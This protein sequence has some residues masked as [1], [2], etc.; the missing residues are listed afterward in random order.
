MKSIV[1]LDLDF[2]H[3]FMTSTFYKC[4][5]TEWIMKHILVTIKLIHEENIVYNIIRV[6]SLL[7]IAYIVCLRLLLKITDIYLSSRAL[8]I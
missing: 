5:Q 8:R 1:V 7:K 4:Q 3:Y 6:D 2:V